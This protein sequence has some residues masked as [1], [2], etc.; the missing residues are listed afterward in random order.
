MLYEVKQ[1]YALSQSV[2]KI[3]VMPFA[4]C[5]NKH[6]QHS[7]KNKIVIVY[8]GTVSIKRKKYNT[9]FKLAQKNKNMEFVLLGQLKEGDGKEE[10]L[11]KIAEYQ[12]NNIKIY[13]DFVPSEEFERQMNRASLLF[14][15]F[16]VEI[17]FGKTTEIYGKTKDSG[18]SYLMLR[19]GVPA[20]TNEEF[21][22][23]PKLGECTI[24]FSNSE[25]ANTKLIRIL[26]PSIRQDLIDR[27][28][29]ASR[30]YSIENF[31]QRLRPVVNSII[32]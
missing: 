4:L 12:I 2:E 3:H 8:P 13:F 1:R 14:S 22:N 15:D 10:I 23:I 28:T 9:F 27:I 32:Y 6:P 31:A 24:G 19:Y 20:L 21:T 26:D 7:N 29:E 11:A 30:Y 18:I 5:T 16:P 17:E 25:D